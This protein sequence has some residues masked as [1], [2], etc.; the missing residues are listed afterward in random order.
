MRLNFRRRRRQVRRIALLPTLVTLGNGICGFTAIFKTAEGQFEWAA[1]LIL[2]G[3]VF[4]ALDGRVARMTGAVSKFGAQ[5]DSLCDLVTFG[6]AP[7][8]LARGILLEGPAVYHT[9]LPDRLVWIACTFYAMCALI[10]LARFNVEAGPDEE[11]PQDFAGLP[12]P[13]AAGVV[14][15]VI[16]ATDRVTADLRE[17]SLSG[18]GGAG[19]ALLVQGLPLIVFILGLLMTSRV[20]YV[21]IVN[22]FL[23]GLSSFVTLLEVLLLGVVLVLVK[24]TAFLIVFGGYALWGPAV[25]LKRR[26]SRVPAAAGAEPPPAGDEHPEI[27]G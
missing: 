14:A 1:W 5:M 27:F 7:A 6:V 20:S 25:A 26:L 13:A 24:E 15:S 11:S 21:H 8:F 17:F 18:G 23:R 19:D 22:R 10:R 4:D 16:L 12:T 3:M 9:R 2:L